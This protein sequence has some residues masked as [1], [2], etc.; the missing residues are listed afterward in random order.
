MLK[1]ADSDTALLDVNLLQLF[2]LLYS[3]RSVTRA[4]EQ[5]DLAVR[6]LSGQ[7]SFEPCLETDG[8]LEP[9]YFS[10][11]TAAMLAE[12]VWGAGFAAPLFQGHFQVLH[13]RVLKERHLKLFLEQSLNT[14][15][16]S[17]RLW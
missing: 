14:N 4:A 9:M 16:R 13:Q 15:P 8:A 12:Q 11:E 10:V 5:L 17:P 3:T 2:V 6:T 1:K 7:D